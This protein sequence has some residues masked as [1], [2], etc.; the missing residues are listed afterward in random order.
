MTKELTLWNHQKEALKRWSNTNHLGLF[1]D[2]GTG[3]TATAII[4][5]HQ[6]CQEE[7]KH[8]LSAFIVPNNVVENWSREH[9][10]W[11]PEGYEASKQVHVVAGSTWQVKTKGVA[12]ALR[13]KK[14]IFIIPHS[15]LSQSKQVRELLLQVAFEFVCVDECHKMKNPSAWLTKATTFMAHRAKYRMVLTGTPILNTYEDIYSQLN[16]LDNR[17]WGDHNF[18]SWRRTYFHDKNAGKTWVKF[19]DWSPTQAGLELIKKTIAQHTVQAKK[20]YVLD[21]PP[22]IRTTIHVDLAPRAARHYEDLKKGFVTALETEDGCDVCETD[23]IVTQM[24]RMRQV[25]SGNLQ[26]E[27]E[28]HDIDCSKDAELK[29]LLTDLTPDHKVIVWCDFVRPLQRIRKLLDSMNLYHCCITGGQ[30]H[31]ERQREIDAFN[32]EDK[33]RVMVANQAAGGVGINLQAAS[34]M[35][36]FSKD[37]DLEKDLQ[38]EARAYRGGSERHQSVT[39]IDIVS[40]GTIEEEVTEALRHKMKLGELIRNMKEK[41]CGN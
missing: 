16:I 31:T 41:Y 23:L 11:A 30:S 2:M 17:I 25:C 40:R 6:K 19:P 37:Y 13:N 21:L 24:L 4:A 10:T 20:E 27:E 18:Y 38:S 7:G 12:E 5:Y 33:Y 8:L 32:H 26:G 1:F 22:F 35:I 9:G 14:S 39:R 3:K 15:A 29:D 36:Y 28:L 34:Y